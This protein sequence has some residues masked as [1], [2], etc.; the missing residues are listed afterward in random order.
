ML[1][2]ALAFPRRLSQWAA[3]RGV[4]VM[5]VCHSDLRLATAGLAR[6]L[7]TPATAALAWAQRRALATPDLVL[8]AS[9][10]SA[11]GIG[12]LV[13]GTMV[14]SPLGVDLEPFRSARPD[15][16]LRRRL[17]PDDVPL[18]LYAGRLSS[19]KRVDVLPAVLAALGGSAVARDRRHGG[20]LAPAHAL[21]RRAWGS[22]AASACWA[23]W[24]SATGW[25]R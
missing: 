8:V 18:L 10:A 23:T 5:M 6:P 20:G 21:R 7:A 22:R 25:P 24:P 19:E 17:A 9:R 14:R 3:R 12:G 13:R 2:D 1:H 16:A 4:P 11:R 15:P